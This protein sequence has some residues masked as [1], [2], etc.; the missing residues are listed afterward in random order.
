MVRFSRARENFVKFATTLPQSTWNAL[1]M[2]KCGT[3]VD[4]GKVVAMPPLWHVLRKKLGK[5]RGFSCFVIQ[6]VR[7]F[8]G[9]NDAVS[10]RKWRTFS[11]EVTQKVGKCVSLCWR[12]CL[13][14]IG[15]ASVWVCHEHGFW[16]MKKWDIKI[17]VSSFVYVCR[18]MTQ[19]DCYFCCF[20]LALGDKLQ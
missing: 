1:Y 13:F 12:V 19:C 6:K 5:E 8:L 15:S 10:L 20:E 16:R 4:T 7:H 2:G 11:G 9:E 3:V 17:G 14:M 18:D